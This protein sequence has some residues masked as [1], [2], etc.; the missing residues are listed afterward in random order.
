M[1]RWAG[2]LRAASAASALLTIA[3]PSAAAEPGDEPIHVDYAAG[4]GCPS[5]EHFLDQLRSFTPRWALAP[6]DAEARRFV[7]R[8]TSAGDRYIG[9]FDLQSAPGSNVRRDVRGETCEDVASGLAVAVALA[10]DARASAVP[11]PEPG[12]GAE[13]P[14]VESNGPPLPEASPPLTTD[15][16]RTPSPPKRRSPHSPA[17]SELRTVVSAGAR[18]DAHGAVSVVLPTMVAFV[19][20][21]WRVPVGRAPL[22]AVRPV[23]RGGVRQ[24]FTRT[25]SAGES[26]V[27][28]QWRAGF[29]EACPTRLALPAHISL[30][31]CFAFNVGQLSAEARNLAEAR[32]TR[33]WLDSGVVLGARWQA[34]RHVFVELSAG[35]WYPIIRDRIRVEPNRIVSEAPPLGPSG[36]VGAGYLF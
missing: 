28:I 21:A 18:L 19:D 33:L 23:V 26:H 30:E 17:E 7:L 16:H 1:G 6:R 24:S 15:N 14:P 4:P 9:S 31:G 29:V 25:A 22:F 10:I 27:D 13:P 32:A 35:L 8:I 5:A 3:P 2:P 20:V 34:H 36:G 11:T 12:P